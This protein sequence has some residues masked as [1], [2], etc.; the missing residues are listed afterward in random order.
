MHLANILKI[1][2]VQLALG[3]STRSSGIDEVLAKLNGDAR[4]TD[5]ESLRKTVLGHDAALL[6]S[7]GIGICIAHGRSQGLKSLVVAAG[8]SD[9]GLSA[10]DGEPATRLIFVAGIPS[11]MNAQYLTVVG[12]I[13][14][15]CSK[16]RDLDRLLTA[17]S[18]EEFIETLQSACTNN[19]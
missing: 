4:V 17:K 11:A 19:G 15:V 13:A 3:A 10:P 12:A 8:R 2:D 16:K 5:W 1:D 9:Q 18:P 7:S 14:R 6:E